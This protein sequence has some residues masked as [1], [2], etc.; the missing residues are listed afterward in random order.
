VLTLLEQCLPKE[1]SSDLGR[2]GMELWSILVIGTLRLG[3]NADYDRIMELANEHKT[4]RQML[5]HGLLDEDKRYGLQ[6]IKDNVILITPKILDLINQIIVNSGHQLLGK[7]GVNLNGRCDSF[8]LETNVRYPTDTTL[9]VDAMRKIIIN[10]GRA[11]GTFDNVHGWRQYH[12]NYFHIKNL[13]RLAQ[14]LKRSTSQDTNKIAARDELIVD[15]HQSLLDLSQE[16]VERAEQTIIALETYG[17]DP[18]AMSYINEIREF[19]VHAKRQIDQIYRRVILGEVI[20]HSEKVFSIFQEH[21]EWIKKGKAGVPVELGMR[22]CVL[23]D[24]MGFILHHQVMEKE[25]DDKVAVSIVKQAQERFPNLR[26]CSFDKGFHSKDNRDQ[27]EQI[28]D[29]VV[30]PKKG[31]WSAADRERETDAEFVRQRKQHSAV[32]SA[33]NALEVH[34]L[35][36]CPDNGLNGFKRYVAWAVVA[37]NLHKLGTILRDQEREKIRKEKQR[38]ERRK[39]A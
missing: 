10:C 26:V 16:Y 18:L 15:A 19:L 1:T 32:E 28:L 33:I 6:T 11:Q 12:N 27:L 14:K 25:T 3:L 24:N 17:A 22:V 21:T 8:V 4:I 38:L 36:R 9:L 34:G 2:P 13:Q 20:P 39:A 35:D 7:D 31:K 5:G 29:L 30:L 37:R 23:E